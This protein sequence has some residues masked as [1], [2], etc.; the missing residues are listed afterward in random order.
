MVRSLLNATAPLKV[1]FHE[2]ALMVSV[3]L[4]TMFIALVKVG[5]AAALALNCKV[6]A[7]PVLAASPMMIVPLP[8]KALE[9]LAVPTYKVP[10]WIVV[11]PV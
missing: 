7:A 9:L 2:V 3:P 4:P 10:A 5:K 6:A 1:G 8:P 11:V